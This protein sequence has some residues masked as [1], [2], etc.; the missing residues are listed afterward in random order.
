MNEYQRQAYLSTL[1]VENYMPRWQLFNAPKSTVCFIPE[2]IHNQPKVAEV[3]S[4]QSFDALGSVHEVQNTVSGKPV[5]FAE[6]LRDLTPEKKPST[7]PVREFTTS[8]IST[9]AMPTAIPGFSLSIWRPQQDLL[10]LDTRNTQLAL[11][12]ELL[13]SSLLW[14][15]FGRQ[16]AAGNEDVLRWP[17]VDN[18]AVSRTID[19]ARSVLQVWLEVE[20]ERRPVKHL[21]LMGERAAQF[22]LPVE[23]EYSSVLFNEI[24]MKEYSASAIIAPGLVELLQQPLL[25]RDLWNA[26]ASWHQPV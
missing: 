11:P 20:L 23:V 12:T 3:L 14:A 25:K 8:N 19:D 21:L 16:I 7:Q 15:L 22:F 6:V 5:D 26:L 4:P 24:H 13:L 18:T 9:V 2:V 10:I 1:G 17:M